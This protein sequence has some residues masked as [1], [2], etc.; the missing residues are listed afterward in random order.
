M[1]KMPLDTLIEKFIGWV[2]EYGIKLIIGLIVISI[3]LKIIKKVVKQFGVF[4]EKRDV[5]VTLRRFIQSLTAGVLKVILFI[6]ILGYW[7][8]KLTGL[9]AIVASGG[10]AIGLALQGSLSNFAGGFIILLLRPFKVGDYI[11]TGVYEGTVEEIGL[12]YT[13]LTTIDNKLIL[14]PNGTLS[15]GSLINYSAKEERRVDLTFSVGYE[16]NILHVKE[17]LTDIVKRQEFVLDNPKP[18]IGVSAH[19]PSSVDFIVKVWCKSEHYWD[20]HF[21]LLEKVKLRFDEENISIPYP[22]MDLHVKKED[23]G[24]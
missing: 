21:S 3:G 11:Q 12:F 9:A 1:S 8:V 6:G 7:D 23:L 5:D 19:S 24:L 2:T 17:V 22:Q 15:N 20:I 13:K 16:N 14:I 4:L 10:V 18:F